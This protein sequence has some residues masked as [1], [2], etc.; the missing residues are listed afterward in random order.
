MCCAGYQR[1]LVKTGE[2]SSGQSSTLFQKKTLKSTMKPGIQQANAFEERARAIARGDPNM[3]STASL[4]V[5]VF[6]NIVPV[7]MDREEEGKYDPQILSLEGSNAIPFARSYIAA[8]LESEPYKG[9]CQI[10]AFHAIENGKLVFDHFRQ[11]GEPIRCS[12]CGQPTNHDSS[13]WIK[14]F[15]M[16]KS[17]TTS[18]TLKLILVPSCWNKECQEIALGMCESQSDAL[19]EIVAERKGKGGRGMRH[20]NQC[21]L[22]GKTGRNLL[23]CSRCRI[24]HYCSS[25]CQVADWKKEH[26]NECVEPLFHCEN[27]GKKGAGMLRCARCKV[28]RY[29]NEKCQRQHWKNGGHK[30]QCN[31]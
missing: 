22:C 11:Q 21:K 4:V 12:N 1:E 15:S 27:C 18:A 9:Q 10:R 30:Q 14:I 16:E 2:I 3:R 19:D 23:R 8:G 20:I 24:A 26:K 25:E 31:K 7:E 17:D 6:N 28:A 5:R 13:L 29:C